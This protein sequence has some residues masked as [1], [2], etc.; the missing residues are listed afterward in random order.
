MAAC[1]ILFALLIALAVAAA[2]VSVTLASGH[3]A[4]RT[5]MAG[6]TQKHD[7]HGMAP[8]HSPDGDMGAKCPGDGS[9]CCKLTGALLVQP[10][11]IIAV[12]AVERGTE[13][14]EP[15]GWSTK[16]RPPPPRS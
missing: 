6:Q 10:L 1:R 5:H 3:A 8:A 15:A 12:A 11:P 2:P 13:P 4:A 16:P 14:P 9:K 7:C